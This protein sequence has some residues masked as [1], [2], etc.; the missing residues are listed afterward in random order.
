VRYIID[1]ELREPGGRG[2]VAALHRAYWE[3]M[4]RRRIL[5]YGGAWSDGRGET[6][7]LD[8]GNRTALQEVLSADPYVQQQVVVRSRIRELD[9]LVEGRATEAA[10]PRP[11]PLREL[12]P[13]ERRIARMML[14][15]LTN[16]EIAER[17]GVSPRAVEQHITKIY[18]KLSISRR[19]QLPAALPAAAASHA[20]H[21]VP[22]A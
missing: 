2:G 3:N 14:D 22:V 20:G 8:I 5:V 11:A 6:L 12:N 7:L 21:R 4:V 15:G 19:A 9:S 18:R 17:L 1:R 13:H 10:G 16:R